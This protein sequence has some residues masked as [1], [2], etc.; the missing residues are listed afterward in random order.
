MYSKVAPDIVKTR[1]AKAQQQ[2]LPLED[3]CSKPL[4]ETLNAHSKAIGCPMEFLYYPLLSITAGCMGVRSEI[5]INQEWKEPAILW[6]AVG[7]RKGEKKTPACSRLLKPLFDIQ[8]SMRDSCEEGEPRPQ[9]IID[10]FSFEE[11]HS[12][13]S[14]N[15]GQVMGLYD[16]LESFWQSLDVYKPAGCSMDRKTLLKL[17][18]GY[19]WQRNYRSVKG[20]LPRTCLNISG[21]IQ[22][23]FLVDLLSTN[24]A[25]G[26]TDRHLLTCPPEVR[27]R[28]NYEIVFIISK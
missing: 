12:V 25:D 10:Q 6:I 16:E 2:T 28:N 3:V 18:N 26:F 21:F 15:G 9:L 17:Y 20:F 4:Y 8:Q 19:H 5:Q 22:P 1:L 13:M 14:N 23:Q 11:L 24:D 7:A 27:I